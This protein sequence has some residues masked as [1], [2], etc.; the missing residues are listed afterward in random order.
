M[1]RPINEGKKEHLSFLATQGGVQVPQNRPLLRRTH[2]LG[3]FALHGG[4][5]G[6]NVSTLVQE[7]ELKEIIISVSRRVKPNRHADPLHACT[8][9]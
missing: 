7:H 4:I 8:A 1:G 9:P 5:P 6:E 2:N 3:L